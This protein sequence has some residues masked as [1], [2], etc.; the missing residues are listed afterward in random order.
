[1]AHPPR[2][3]FLFLAV[4]HV[5]LGE[6]AEA[7]GAVEKIRAAYPGMS[8]DQ[9]VATEDTFEDRS[10]SDRFRTI[11]KRVEAEG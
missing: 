7:R 9:V 4:C 5:E 3:A 8:I 6:M 11:L 2:W 1:M 10:V